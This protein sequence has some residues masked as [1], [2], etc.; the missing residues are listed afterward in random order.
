M[1]NN[2]SDIWLKKKKSYR[3]I[4]GHASIPEIN[5]YMVDI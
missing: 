5:N 1:P 2:G 3:I 4:T